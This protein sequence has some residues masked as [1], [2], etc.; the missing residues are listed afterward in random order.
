MDNRAPLLTRVR[1]S[2]FIDLVDLSGNAS[3]SDTVS[4]AILPKPIL[5]SPENNANVA[6]TD[7]VFQ[8]NHTGATGYYRA[9]VL[10][11]NREY[12]WHGDFYQSTEPDPLEIR[13]PVNIAMEQSGNSLYWRIDSFEYDFDMDMYIGSES[14][15]R[16][17][18]IQ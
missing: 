1:Y 9:V 10:D 12:V 2:Y 3:R 14:E 16:L 17:I 7:V 13:F 11:S 15:E 5:L 18:F 6:A 4:Y 8:W